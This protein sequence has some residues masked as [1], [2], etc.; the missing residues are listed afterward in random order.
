MVIC[1][2]ENGGLTITSIMG[3]EIMNIN[4]FHSIK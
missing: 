2:D 3:E 4:P 1:R